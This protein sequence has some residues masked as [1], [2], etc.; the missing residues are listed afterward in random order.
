MRG[1][2]IGLWPLP[3][4]LRNIVDRFVLT[5]HPDKLLWKISS[6]D[7]FS[8]KQYYL[9]KRAPLP[10]QHLIALIWQSWIPPK[11]NGLIWKLF[12]QVVPTDNKIIS[13]GFQMP[14]KSRCCSFPTQESSA[15]LFL[16]SDLAR[17]GWRFL[18]QVF[19]KPPPSSMLSL[20]T[21][22]FASTNPKRFLDCLALGMAASLLLEIWVARNK[23]LHGENHGN[24]P[25][26]LI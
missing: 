25:A 17:P 12:H 23:V 21:Y 16:H 14:S 13:L 7:S 1:S 9:A 18:A 8:V 4:I 3:P 20:K 5:D 6:N 2:G 11:I 24:I 15:H 26:L 22:W 19:D 10:K